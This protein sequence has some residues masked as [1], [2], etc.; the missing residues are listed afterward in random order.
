MNNINLAS[1]FFFT[2]LCTTMNSSVGCINKDGKMLRYFFYHIHV[3]S[4]FRT[5]TSMFGKCMTR[6]ARDGIQVTS[7]VREV[8][9]VLQYINCVTSCSW[10]GFES[11]LKVFHDRYDD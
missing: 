4:L 10:I 9:M 8:W 11:V 5:K 1:L 7:K 3:T 6:L 2:Q